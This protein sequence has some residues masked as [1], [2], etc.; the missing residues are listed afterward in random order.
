MPSDEMNATLAAMRAQ[1]SGQLGSADST[2]EERR[3]MIDGLGDVFPLPED[4]SVAEVT[5]GGVPGLWLTPPEVSAEAVLL[6]LHGGGYQLGSPRSHRELAA[7]LARAAGV[8]ALIVDYR[9]APEHRF[10]AALD[11]ALAAYRWL[12]DDRG[13]PAGSIVLAGDSA[14]GG[15]VAATLV[16]ARDRGLPLP[17]AAALL[18]PWADLTGSG[19][20][21]VTN[22]ET[23]PILS[24]DLLG[25]MARSYA[26][27]TDLADPLVS[28]VFADLTGLPP[29]SVDAGTAELLLDDGRRLAAAAGRAGVEVVLTEAE[30]MPHVWHVL[31]LTPEATAATDRVG[32]FLAAH[33][34]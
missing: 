9:L 17:A 20:S 19:A 3:T 10:P 23:D 18:S 30:G 14:G 8:R 22:A 21:M 7:R 6:Y 34:A 27:A 24:A 11:D 16:A 13:V 32:A 33:L 31:A 29:L 28:P 4:V 26:G 15:L 1:S 12:L 5:A 25:E 2:V